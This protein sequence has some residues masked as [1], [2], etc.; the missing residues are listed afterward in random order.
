MFSLLGEL[1]TKLIAGLKF[2]LP[3]AV[4]IVTEQSD[5]SSC[6]LLWTKAAYDYMY[7]SGETLLRNFPVQA[8]IQVVDMDSD[9]S[10]E[11]DEED[12]EYDEQ[13]NA[14]I[15]KRCDGQGNKKTCT[16][17]QERENTKKFKQ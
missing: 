13:D 17:C 5:F 7:A 11:E 9:S 6:R 3:F 15:C 8:T 16:Q 2:K 14:R 1:I 12:Y 10:D 4:I